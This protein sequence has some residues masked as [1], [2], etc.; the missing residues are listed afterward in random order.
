M[1]F[2]RQFESNINPVDLQELLTLERLPDLCASIDSLLEYHGE[3]GQIYCLWG[4]F[5]VNRE[6]IRHGVRFSLPGCPNA[7]A[8]SIT[9]EQALITIHCT[10]NRTDHEPA[11]IESIDQ[12]VDDWQ[13]GLQ[14]LLDGNN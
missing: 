13:A 8:W 9:T 6:P 7:L 14:Q 10:I 12:F 11:F 4:S 3:S 2:F 5:K 1:E